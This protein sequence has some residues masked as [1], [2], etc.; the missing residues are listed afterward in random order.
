MS[1]FGDEIQQS[2]AVRT[3]LAANQAAIEHLSALTRPAGIDP[4][5]G[6][7]ALAAAPAC[8]A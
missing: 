3:S 6:V 1:A 7:S 4:D 8:A 2:T 5:P